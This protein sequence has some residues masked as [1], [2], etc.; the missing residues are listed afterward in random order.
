MVGASVE[1]DSL[2][3]SPQRLRL[4]SSA[5]EPDTPPGPQPNPPPGESRTPIVRNCDARATPK[6]HSERRAPV[7]CHPVHG[8]SVYSV[9]SSNV[10]RLLEAAHAD[11]TCWAAMQV[12]RDLTSTRPAEKARWVRPEY[13]IRTQGDCDKAQTPLSHSTLQLL[14]QVCQ[15]PA[16]LWLLGGPE[17]DQLCVSSSDGTLDGP[18]LMDAAGAD[19]ACKTLQVCPVCTDQH[20]PTEPH[21]VIYAALGL[22]GCRPGGLAVSKETSCAGDF[23]LEVSLTNQGSLESSN[24]SADEASSPPEI[25]AG[26]AVFPTHKTLFHAYA[27]TPLC[28]VS[29]R[30][31][32]LTHA[33]PLVNPKP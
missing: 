29:S 12:P 20:R 24:L 27:E 26:S 31:Q 13:G 15:G 22:S 5:G 2:V 6:G 17:N 10:S 28:F 32:R 14:A 33:D 25:V 8:G 4:D 23:V 7:E 21:I 1:E 18:V 16:R 11:V 19:T 3:A 30:T 9:A